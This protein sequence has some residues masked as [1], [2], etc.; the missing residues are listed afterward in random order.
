[1]ALTACKTTGPGDGEVAGFADGP[2]L[3]AAKD[4]FKNTLVRC[5]PLITAAV[6]GGRA[7]ALDDSP[8]KLQV[9]TRFVDSLVSPTTKQTESV[10]FLAR[11][12]Q[13]EKDQPVV[14]CVGLIAGYLVPEFALHTNVIDI[15][16][17]DKAP[18]KLVDLSRK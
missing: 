18:L 13:M 17:G 2:E 7:V 8:E 12:Y 9:V 15:V 16:M 10:E 14:P 1:L 3:E 6:P 11:L 4:R 5:A